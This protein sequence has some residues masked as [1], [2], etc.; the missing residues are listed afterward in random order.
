MR[1]EPPDWGLLVILAGVLVS[2]FGE[3]K[4]AHLQMVYGNDGENEADREYP[5][6]Y[7]YI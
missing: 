1:N 7:R 3:G 6:K 4:I 2:E 5:E